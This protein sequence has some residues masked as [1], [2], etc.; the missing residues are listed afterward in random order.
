MFSNGLACDVFLFIAWLGSRL[1]VDMV[2]SLEQK[3]KSLL[4]L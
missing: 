4:D 2:L 1:F 3:C